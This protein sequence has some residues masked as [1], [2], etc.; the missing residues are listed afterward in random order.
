MLRARAFTGLPFTGQ[1]V[2]LIAENEVNDYA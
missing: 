1:L 2:E